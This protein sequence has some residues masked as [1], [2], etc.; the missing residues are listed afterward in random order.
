M[1]RGTAVRIHAPNKT[2]TIEPDP[3]NDDR[4][5]FQTAAYGAVTTIEAD[6]EEVDTLIDFLI[7]WLDR[8]N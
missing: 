6:D 7:E 5:R 1:K 3:T 2:L 8:S 4:V